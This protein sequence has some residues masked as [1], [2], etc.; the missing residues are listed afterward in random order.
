MVYDSVMDIMSVF[1]L[2]PISC[3]Y[4]H[5]FLV[6][7]R[8]SNAVPLTSPVCSRHSLDLFVDQRLG[9]VIHSL[10]HLFS[11]LAKG[12]EPRQQQHSLVAIKAGDGDSRRVKSERERVS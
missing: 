10:T 5:D 6:I 8:I 2:P 11:H 3:F 9:S 4:V 7:N 12:R 1:F